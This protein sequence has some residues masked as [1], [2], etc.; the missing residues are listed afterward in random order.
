M[1]NRKPKVVAKTAE[2]H[3]PTDISRPHAI[4]DVVKLADPLR[5]IS[6]SVRTPRLADPSRAVDFRK[7]ITVCSEAPPLDG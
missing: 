6:V 3:R 7:E 5:K 4:Q 2:I 1:R